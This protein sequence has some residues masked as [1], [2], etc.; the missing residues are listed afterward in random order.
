MFGEGAEVHI[1][2]AMPFEPRNSNLPCSF[3]GSWESPVLRYAG[4]DFGDPATSPASP[5]RPFEP[6]ARSEVV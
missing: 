6:F 4:C 1:A 2:L 3:D 5:G